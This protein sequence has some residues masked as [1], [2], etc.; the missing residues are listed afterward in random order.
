MKKITLK[1]GRICFSPQTCRHEK[2]HSKILQHTLRLLKFR[3]NP[4]KKKVNRKP[5]L[6][7]PGYWCCEASD[8][9][10]SVSDLR[11]SGLN[12]GHSEPLN[13]S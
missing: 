5:T 6:S 8:K 3:L 9:T 4:K 12:I 1:D 11:R 10:D 7:T 2:Y 13:N